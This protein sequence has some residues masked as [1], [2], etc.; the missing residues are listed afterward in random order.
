MSMD[1]RY[2]RWAPIAVICLTLWMAPARAGVTTTTPSDASLRVEAGGPG[3][4][5]LFQ[6]HDGFSGKKNTRT[7]VITGSWSYGA[8]TQCSLAVQGLGLG[9]MVTHGSRPTFVGPAMC[10]LCRAVS[11]S[12][13]TV[14]ATCNGAWSF[15]SRHEVDFP[16][17]YLLFKQYPSC[18]HTP[19]TFAC[20]LTT[21]A[22]L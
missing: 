16:A 5:C 13:V 19:D 1:V 6:L 14:C 12:G 2:V 18:T 20:T 4:S 10:R 3:P 8:S 9:I 11:I 7:G 15:T 22:R 17:G 21:S